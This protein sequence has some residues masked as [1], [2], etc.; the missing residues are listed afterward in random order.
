MTINAL[1]SS[2]QTPALNST[3]E[4]HR[5]SQTAQSTTPPVPAS[6]D[7]PPR[8]GSAF[9]EAVRQTLSQLGLSLDVSRAAPLRPSGTGANE[10]SAPAASE[11]K[12]AAPQSSAGPALHTFLHDLFS[13]LRTLQPPSGTG[14]GNNNPSGGTSNPKSGPSGYGDLSSQLLD[15]AKLLG[16]GQDSSQNDLLSQLK[17]DY[18]KLT[19]ALSGSSG[20]GGQLPDLKTFLQTLAK[21]VPGQKS[22]E[23]TAGTLLNTA[24]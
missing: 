18:Q 22:G 6:G 16:S 24:I 15:L 7:H 19:A 10:G 9:L 17:N 4:A 2:L 11:S 14:S 21:N 3:R 1:S 20:H 5:G 13:A 23:S 12:A 8:G